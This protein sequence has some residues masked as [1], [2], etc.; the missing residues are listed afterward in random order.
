MQKNNT[1]LKFLADAPELSATIAKWYYDEW[2]SDENEITFDYIHDLVINK[3]S[4]KNQLPL[5]I[6]L[7]VNDELAGVAELKYRENKNHPEYTHWLGGIYV[8]SK[9]RG[10]G[11]SA[12]LIERAKQ[13]AKEL[14]LKDLYLQAEPHNVALY[15]KHGFRQLH[16]AEHAGIKTIIMLTHLPK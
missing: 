7:M 9:F 3:A 11:L 15:E 1:S 14:A 13:V 8:D 6:I 5:S 4:N 12:Q 2:G 10:L 16:E